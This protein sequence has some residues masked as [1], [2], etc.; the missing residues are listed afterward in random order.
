MFGTVIWWSVSELWWTCRTLVTCRTVGCWW[1][2]ILMMWFI[3]IAVEWLELLY[4][5]LNYGGNDLFGCLIIIVIKLYM[6][7]YLWWFFI[8]AWVVKLYANWAGILLSQYGKKN[9]KN[10]NKWAKKWTA[11][12]WA[13]W[14]YS[15][16]NCK[17][18]AMLY[19]P[20]GLNSFLW[21]FVFVI[22]S[23]PR[24]TPR[25]APRD[26]TRHLSTSRQI[27]YDKYSDKYCRHN[28]VTN[29]QLSL[30]LMTTGSV[31]HRR[32]IMTHLLWPQPYRHCCVI[33]GVQWQEKDYNCHNQLV[34][35]GLTSCS[36]VR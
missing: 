15:N 8:W 29:V 18:Q 25:C 24:H 21:Q 33:E 19:G 35:E 16:Y 9:K 12:I 4:E 28:L 32:G 27:C 30:R 13:N 23:V 5:P 14:A 22:L 2:C 34:I 31:S 1:S 3:C 26:I 20:I 36:E 6:V 17:N 7:Y 10:V 11:Y